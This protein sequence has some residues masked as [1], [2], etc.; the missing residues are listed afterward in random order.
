MLGRRWAQSL[1]QVKEL[2][3]VVPAG[4][5]GLVGI[6]ELPVGIAAQL[7]VVV[8]PVVAFVDPAVLV[9]R[10]A[11]A[12]PVLPESPPHWSE[13]VAHNFAQRSVMVSKQLVL[14]RVGVSLWLPDSNRN[15]RGWFL[16][17]ILLICS[18]E[19]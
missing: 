11:V 6:V 18:K 13:L 19:V 5:A 14:I 15:G 8:V 1:A 17:H 9:A 3:L 2:V 4:I 12:A 16:I 7:E 10:T